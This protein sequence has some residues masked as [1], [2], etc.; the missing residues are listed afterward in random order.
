MAHLDDLTILVNET[1]ALD[2]N[3]YPTV[4]IPLDQ[5]PVISYNSINP[6]AKAEYIVGL[7]E[8]EITGTRIEAGIVI[9]LTNG[10]LSDTV[11][12]DVVY[13]PT[14]EQ[15]TTLPQTLGS[16]IRLFGV[17]D[18]IYWSNSGIFPPPTAPVVSSDTSVLAIHTASD[19]RKYAQAVS[20]GSAEITLNRFHVIRVTVDNTRVFPSYYR[21]PPGFEVRVL[22]SNLVNLYPP[23]K[24]PTAPYLAALHVE[25][26]AFS[27][28]G[29]RPN[30]IL[31]INSRQSIGAYRGQI[32]VT[33]WLPSLLGQQFNVVYAYLFV[34]D[35]NGEDP[36]TTDLSPWIPI[37]TFEVPTSIGGVPEN[38]IQPIDPGVQAAFSGTFP[39]KVSEKDLTF[40]LGEVKLNKDGIELSLENES[41]LARNTARYKT[42]KFFEY[43]TRTPENWYVTLGFETD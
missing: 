7:Q 28:T 5:A 14:S 38:Q 21:L 16:P 26:D 41:V 3:D 35:F 39:E 20:I 6:S 32:T 10:S 24:I 9:T 8:L 36:V 33:Q 12:V 37:S 15:Q 17:G 1:K 40:S 34:T 2:L 27:I 13:S 18:R 22:S 43:L 42:S 29:T 19:G 23:D 11:G 31:V 4:T 30:Q 25:S